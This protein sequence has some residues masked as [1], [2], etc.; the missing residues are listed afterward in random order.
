MVHSYS[1]TVCS[2]VIFPTLSHL[3]HGVG[4]FVEVWG[5]QV[6]A[7]EDGNSLYT[8]DDDNPW[9][10]VSAAASAATSATR[11]YSLSG[12]DGESHTLYIQ[13]NGVTMQIAFFETAA[14]ATSAQSSS[15]SATTSSSTSTFL[16]CVDSI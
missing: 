14:T 4:S 16:P 8:V 12:L 9:K 11:L 1:L 3:S 13:N 2:E 6:S 7:K 10:S 5:L 15:S